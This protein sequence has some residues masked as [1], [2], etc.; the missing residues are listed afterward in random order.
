V[1]VVVIFGVSFGL[2]F[3]V[4]DWFGCVFLCYVVVVICFEN[5]Q[6]LFIYVGCTSSSE[7]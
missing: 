1:V 3:C 5:K 6:L 4:D 7:A 2:F